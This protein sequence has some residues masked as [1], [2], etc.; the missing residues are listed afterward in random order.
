MP[1][2]R[3]DHDGNECLK[4]L[5]EIGIEDCKMEQIVRLGRQSEDGRDRPLLMKMS[6]EKEKWKIL[7]QAKPL[8]NFSSRNRV[9]P[10]S[11]QGG[12]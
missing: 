9:T 4:I 12:V 3:Y 11:I 10:A 1:A 5:K 8:W 7:S 2:T 6:T